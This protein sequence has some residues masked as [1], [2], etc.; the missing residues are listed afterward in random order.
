MKIK[1]YAAKWETDNTLEGVTLNNRILT[2]KN[3]V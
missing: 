2:Y 3:K 1:D